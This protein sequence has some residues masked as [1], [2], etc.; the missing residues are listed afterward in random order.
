MH[1]VNT[2]SNHL[3]HHLLTR[4]DVTVKRGLREL[5]EEATAHATRQSAREFVPLP[6]LEQDPKNLWGLLL[7]TGYL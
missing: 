2:S 5:L 1:W 4:A 6:E 3:V 7:A